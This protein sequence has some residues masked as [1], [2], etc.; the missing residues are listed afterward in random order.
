MKKLI[1]LMLV[2]LLLLSGCTLGQERLK[3]PVSFYYLRSHSDSDAYQSFFSEG[4]IGAESREA[5]GH[6]QDLTYLLTMYLQGPLSEDLE[7][8]FPAGCRAIE[9]KQE[10]QT[11]SIS[12]N[13]VVSQLGEMELT[14]ACAC[15]AKT[16]LELTGVDTVYMESRN[17]DGDALFTRIFTA[18]NL[19]LEDDYTQPTE[20][21]E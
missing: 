11:L 9:I 7:N 12:L 16:C 20:A 5:S 6:R 17:P 13:A 3:E 8:P 2:F 1:C 15:L 19:L 14:I 4:V 10:D 21:T 18:D